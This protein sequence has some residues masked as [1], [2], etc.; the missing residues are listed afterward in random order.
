MGKANAAFYAKTDEVLV[1]I[2]PRYTS[3][4]VVAFL[5]DIVTYQP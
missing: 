4:E 3:S 1:K 5:T 2:A